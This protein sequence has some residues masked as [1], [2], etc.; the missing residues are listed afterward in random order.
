M[1]IVQ[2]TYMEI[3]HFVRND[4]GIHSSTSPYR[5][6]VIPNAAKRSEESVF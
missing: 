5:S 3:P 1:R 2:Q 6:I 4:K